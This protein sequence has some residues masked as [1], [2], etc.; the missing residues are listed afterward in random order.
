[1]ADHVEVLSARFH[2]IYQKEAHRRGD[3]RH[4]DQYEDLSEETKEWDR[5]LARWVLAN[6]DPRFSF[7]DGEVP[8]P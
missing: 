7:Q 4:A 2:E 5:A 3:V 1:M 8:E 6:F